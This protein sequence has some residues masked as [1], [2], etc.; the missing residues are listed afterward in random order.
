MPLLPGGQDLEELRDQEDVS[1]HVLANLQIPRSA[2][3]VERILRSYKAATMSTRL[4]SGRFHADV[5][6]V[7]A[8]LAAL[9]DAGYV[10]VIRASSFADIADK[11][12]SLKTTIDHLVEDGVDRLDGWV[13]QMERDGEDPTADHY[14]MTH[15]GFEAL[16]G[17]RQGETV[18]NEP[19]DVDPADIR[20]A[21]IGEA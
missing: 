6:D 10:H 14:A 1:R 2:D 13:T 5:A 21:T 3:K 17:H 19:V 9:V 16:N 18:E 4:P 20:P 15:D 12:R 8:T 7:A 11:A